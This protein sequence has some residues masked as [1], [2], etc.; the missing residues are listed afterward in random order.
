M[1]SERSADQG[2]REPILPWRNRRFEVS[3]AKSILAN[4]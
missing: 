1:A 3:K 4:L 2:T